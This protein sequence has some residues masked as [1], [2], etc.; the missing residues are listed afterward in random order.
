MTEIIR[1]VAGI[2]LSST[3]DLALEKA[4]EVASKE[5]RAEVHAIQV[6]QH[7]GDFVQ[8][9]LPQTPA[10]RLPLG[11]AQ[12]K[13]E[14]HVG[15]LLAEWQSRTGRSFSR[16]V[17]HLSVEFPAAAITQLG[18]DLDADLIIVGTH[19]RQGFQR[20]VLGSVAE[21]V[22]RMARCPVLVVRPKQAELPVPEVQ[23]PCGRCLA[24]RERTDGRE[25]WCEQHR[26][27]HGRRHTY[28][29]R[30]RMSDDGNISGLNKSR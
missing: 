17:T 5:E 15:A 29:Y 2:D 11:E 20:L 10:Y 12:E 21:A 23:P 7:L 19:G 14:A 30:N 22:V 27:K 25:T 3:A 26:V 9:D 13:L 8:M 4:F 16:C 6:V 1:I 24:E 18:V 28:H